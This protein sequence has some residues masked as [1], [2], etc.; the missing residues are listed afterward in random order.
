MRVLLLILWYDFRLY[1]ELYSIY[2]VENIL[3][4]VKIIV[5]THVKRLITKVK[6]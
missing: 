2:Y 1:F 4:I 6:K 3:K 5:P